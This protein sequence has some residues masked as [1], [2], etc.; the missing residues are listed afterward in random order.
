MKIVASLPDP[1]AIS[2][3]SR[4]GSKIIRRTIAGSAIW[5]FPRIRWIGE[6]GAPSSRPVNDLV[7]LRDATTGFPDTPVTLVF[8]LMTGDISIRKKLIL[9]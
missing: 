4:D 5:I 3:G 6:R 2:Y 8:V 1:I 9:L 7:L